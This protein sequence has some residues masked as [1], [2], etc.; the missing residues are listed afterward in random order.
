MFGGNYTVVNKV[1]VRQKFPASKY[2]DLRNKMLVSN[3][4]QY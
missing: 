2:Y 1:R 4:I 3:R